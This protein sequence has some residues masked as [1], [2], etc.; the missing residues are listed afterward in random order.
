MV[1]IIHSIS[2]NIRY[3]KILNF[4]VNNYIF[5]VIVAILVFV[6]VTNSFVIIKY[7]G[8]FLKIIL[9]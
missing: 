1:F 2:I 7:Y 5:S 4:V 6:I 8:I 3:K 9:S